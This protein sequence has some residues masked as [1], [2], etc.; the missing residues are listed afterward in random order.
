MTDADYCDT[1]VKVTQQLQKSR[2]VPMPLT[3]SMA[4]RHPLAERI[5]RIMDQRVTRTDRLSVVSVIGVIVCGFLLLTDA[6]GVCSRHTRDTVP[7]L[8]LLT[9][10]NTMVCRGLMPTPTAGRRASLVRAHPG[11]NGPE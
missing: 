1:L 5:T 11:F 8:T 9:F 4:D 3:V 2:R 7:N 10:V 6:V